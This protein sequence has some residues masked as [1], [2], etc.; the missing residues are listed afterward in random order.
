MC[1]WDP[2]V[3]GAEAAPGGFPRGWDVFVPGKQQG[4]V[5][6]L[7]WVSAPPFMFLIFQEALN[8]PGEADRI[9]VRAEA[10]RLF[11]AGVS[12]AIVPAQLE[13]MPWEQGKMSRAVSAQVSFPCSSSWLCTLPGMLSTAALSMANIQTTA[14]TESLLNLEYLALEREDVA[15]GT[16]CLVLS[17]SLGGLASLCQVQGVGTKTGQDSAN[18]TQVLKR[19]GGGERSSFRLC[20]EGSPLVRNSKV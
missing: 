9:A 5:C 20:R 2:S 6:M 3:P 8:S 15:S 7:S 4:V 16:C 10:E 19:K 18:R 12:W 13:E 11:A 14:C 17:C 1:R